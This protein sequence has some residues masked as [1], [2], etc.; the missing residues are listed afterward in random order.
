MDFV[1]PYHEFISRVAQRA[2][3]CPTILSPYIASPD[4][5]VYQSVCKEAMSV[6]GLP[7]GKVRGPMFNL[8]ADDR[9]ELKGILKGL[10]VGD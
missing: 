9:Y 3:P 4:V 10:G 7:G 8:T 6:V 2:G 5:Y 1:A